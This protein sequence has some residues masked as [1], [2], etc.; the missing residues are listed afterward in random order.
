MTEVVRTDFFMCQKC[1]CCNW[2]RD[3]YYQKQIIV[4]E[5]PA[6]HYIP[7]KMTRRCI[8]C[9]HEEVLG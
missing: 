6:D 9:G 1:G 2:F 7:G 5:D 3:I 8:N 4:R